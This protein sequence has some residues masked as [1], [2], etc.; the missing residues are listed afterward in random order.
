M[1]IDIEFLKCFQYLFAA[2]L[3]NELNMFLL[4][5]HFDLRAMFSFFWVD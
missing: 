1:P 5:I 4:Y 2:S 3:I